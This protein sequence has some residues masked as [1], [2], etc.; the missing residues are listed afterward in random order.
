MRRDLALTSNRWPGGHHRS[1]HV[2]RRRDWA[3]FTGVL[4]ALHLAWEFAQSYLFTNFHEQP[5]ASTVLTCLVGTMGDMVL[6]LA[7][8]AAAGAVVHDMQ[9]PFRTER[10]VPAS[11]WVAFGLIVTFGVELLAVRVGAWD[12]THAM[13]RFLG[14]GASPLVQ[15][16]IV[17]IASLWFGAPR[18][19]PSA[20]GPKDGRR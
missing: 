1:R 10:R 20:A 3:R 5:L 4:I 7:A 11:L 2:D 12:Y 13:P 8:L 17:P 9:W 14:V 15:W 18:T 6:S 16:I 19:V